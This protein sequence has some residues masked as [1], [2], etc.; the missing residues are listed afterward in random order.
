MLVDSDHIMS[1][2]KALQRRICMSRILF[3]EVKTLS[4]S[5]IFSNK[6]TYLTSGS[7]HMWS[8]RGDALLQRKAPSPEYRLLWERP[9]PDCISDLQHLPRHAAHGVVQ[10]THPVEPLAPQLGPP[11]A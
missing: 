5:C 7:P 10:V 4:V 8:A 6:N 11:Y 3:I 9:I 1:S 2:A